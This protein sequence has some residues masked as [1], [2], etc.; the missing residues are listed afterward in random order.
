MNKDLLA[1]CRK[2]GVWH[3]V[4]EEKLED[5]AYYKIVELRD[6]IVRLEQQMMGITK[7]PKGYKKILHKCSH[8]L[9]T[10]VIAPKNCTCPPD[11][12]DLVIDPICSEYGQSCHKDDVICINCGHHKE[13]H[14]KKS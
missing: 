14:I 11:N 13:C 12:W 5:W 3:D 10:P 2:D 9:R 7:P 8:G 1:E 4:D 6:E